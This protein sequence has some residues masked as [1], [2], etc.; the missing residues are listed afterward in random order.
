MQKERASS[1]LSILLMNL[2][3]AFLA[4]TYI[5]TDFSTFS[6]PFFVNLYNKAYP[7]TFPALR[8]PYPMERERLT[9]LFPYCPIAL[10]PYPLKQLVTTI[11]INHL[12][13]LIFSIKTC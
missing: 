1:A 5:I 2:G 4:A 7:F 10:L 9:N 12:I 6:T 13:V 11:F 3:A 8:A